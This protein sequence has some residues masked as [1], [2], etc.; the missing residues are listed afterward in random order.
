M[1]KDFKKPKTNDKFVGMIPFEFDD[2][3]KSEDDKVAVPNVIHLVPIGEWAHDVYGPIIIKNSDIRE[4]AQNFNAGVRKGVFITAGHEGFDELPAVGW[5][6]KVETRDNGLWGEVE[7]NEYGMEALQDKQWKFFSPELCRDYED[8]ETHDLYRNV[9]TGGALTKSPYFKELQAIVFSDK[10][11]TSNFNKQTM[12]KT[13][14]EVLALDVATLTDEDKTVLKEN[15]DKLTDEQKVTYADAIKVEE[16]KEEV[17]AETEEEKTARE[18]KEKSDKDIA[19]AKAIEDANVAAGLNPD[20]TAKTSEEIQASEKGMV[21]ISASE[22][23][24][25]TKKANEGAEAFAK[26]EAKELDEST[27]K[28]IFN[29]DS[30]KAGAFLPKSKDT[31]RAFMGKLNPAQRAEFSSLI[32]GLPKNQIFMEKGENGEVEA[33]S[34]AEV[35]AKVKDTMEKNPKMTYSEALKDVMAKNEGL[36]QRY[37]EGL[38]VAKSKK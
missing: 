27:N 15:A 29:S 19:D 17:P 37:D 24:I 12:S 25:L 33:G 4:F 3:D 32:A 5:I 23:A 38:P 18:A 14:E 21:K 22:Y 9:L 35:E 34:M 16:K 20:G 31:L 8:P 30:N 28:L 36:E 7:W 1:T 10:N 26:L 2:G 13:L 6:Q 11:I